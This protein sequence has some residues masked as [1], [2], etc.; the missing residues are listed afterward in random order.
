MA[1]LYPIERDISVEKD[2]TLGGEVFPVGDAWQ[3][4]LGFQRPDHNPM[5][6]T[7]TSATGPANGF[8]ISLGPEGS[9]GEYTWSGPGA[10]PRPTVNRM[11]DDVFKLQRRR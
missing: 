9:D 3:L 1:S 11:L 8:V 4:L 2:N 10:G 7:L 6:G 5:I